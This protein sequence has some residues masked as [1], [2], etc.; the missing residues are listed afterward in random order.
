MTERFPMDGVPKREGETRALDPDCCTNPTCNQRDYN[1]ATILLLDRLAQAYAGFRLTEWATSLVWSCN[2][3]GHTVNCADP[4]C[5]FAR[6]QMLRLAMARQ[7]F[8]RAV[9]ETFSVLAV[10]ACDLSA[11]W[12][13]FFEIE[14]AALG[15]EAIAHRHVREGT[16]RLGDYPAV[17]EFLDVWRQEVSGY[18][19][20][21]YER[22]FGPMT[23][24][25]DDD[26]A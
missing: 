23:P 9:K 17:E 14:Q 24:D 3:E 13:G 4:A 5:T 10:P 6:D 25:D 2:K 19:P 16:P 26:P 20:D 22:W 1:R 11:Q 21:E 12:E 15:L 18:D 7:H 8:E